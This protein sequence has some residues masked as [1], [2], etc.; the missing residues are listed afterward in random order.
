[1]VRI[2][3]LLIIIASCCS[4]TFAQ[5]NQ[6]TVNSSNPYSITIDSIKGITIDG[7]IDEPQWEQASQITKLTNYEPTPGTPL[8]IPVTV[9]IG[10]SHQGLYIAMRASEKQ[11]K[12]FRELSLRDDSQNTDLFGI[13]IDAYGTGS[14][15]YGFSV[16]PKNVQL[17][18]IQQGE[19][20]DSRWDAVWQSATQVTEEGWT[21]EMMIPYSA[22]RFS[23]ADIQSWKFN[24]YYD[25]KNTREM[26]AWSPI[27]VTQEN[28]LNQ[29]GTLIIPSR[30]K[31]PLRLFLYPYAGLYYKP[32]DIKPLQATA[33][34]DLKLGLSE[35]FTLDMTIIPD[36]G[37]VRFDNEVF[38]YS[39]F[40]VKYDENRPFFTEGIDLFDKGSIFYSRRIGE[41]DYTLPPGND[42]ER[43][44]SIP[45]VKLYNA[46]KISGRNKKGLAIGVLNAI[47][48][49]RKILVRDTAT[50]IESKFEVSPLTNKN[51]LVFDQVLKN[52][53]S[54]TLTNASTLRV[55]SAYD[56]NVT[57]LSSYLRDKTQQWYFAGTGILSGRF[58]TGNYTPGYSFLV[59]GGKN[60]GKY[61]YG[62]AYGEVSKKYDPR[63]LGYLAE[64]N[65]RNATANFKIVDAKPREKLSRVNTELE[66]EYSGYID[67]GKFRSLKL[68]LESFILYKNG[69]AIISNMTISPFKSKDYFLTFGNNNFFNTPLNIPAYISINSGISTDFR[70]AFATNLFI[71]WYKWNERKRDGYQ[72]SFEPKLRI[73]DFVSI[74]GSLGWTKYNKD[75]G[76]LITPDQIPNEYIS[77]DL[78]SVRDISILLIELA[79]QV[80]INNNLNVTFEARNYWQKQD[81]NSIHTLASNG[82]LQNPAI[83]TLSNLRGPK[84]Q[85]L[86]LRAVINWRYAPGSDLSFVWS[87]ADAVYTGDELSALG[88]LKNV[89]GL[90]AQ[91]VFSIKLNYF[92]D[93]NRFRKR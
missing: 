22:L 81:I 91:D 73:N 68:D 35:A 84:S 39:A 15:G 41:A 25:K 31:P 47:E 60:A 89:F 10:Y 49:S 2:S 80:K 54:V 76:F 62:L 26:A 72:I 9:Y 42:K 46:F 23:S 43:L 8:S 92:I 79:P 74:N 34:L 59:S 58:E 16:T 65:V 69:F 18:K 1:M 61:Q 38:N 85:F 19:D 32:D 86:N 44:E 37:Q 11:D 30:I 12:I 7:K 29:M 6:G 93:I 5:N 55:G 17:D 78:Y 27:D 28:P 88:S 4:I 51:V 57:S 40:E 67:P 90:N 21:A 36:F 50:G 3:T 53:S 33:G 56:A 24:I 48:G 70:K 75:V 52:N 14:S 20:D 77:K 71:T 64:F 87:R 83:A 13:L 82:D 66:L 63:D 45:D